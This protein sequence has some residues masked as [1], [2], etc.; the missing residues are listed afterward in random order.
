MQDSTKGASWTAKEHATFAF[1]M[2]TR[3][4]VGI[5]AAL[6]AGAPACVVQMATTALAAPYAG[7]SGA[8]MRESCAE[9]LAQ[10]SHHEQ[11]KAGIRQAGGIDVLGSLL[12]VKE[13]STVSKCV[14]AFMGMTIDRESKLLTIQVHSSR[15][16]P[17]RSQCCW[18]V[19]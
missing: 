18:L 10:L 12:G 1:A 14:D 3:C 5:E 19:S 11:G 9:C 8:Q 17:T 6:A 4:D 15:L 16:C 7:A 2:L 13:S